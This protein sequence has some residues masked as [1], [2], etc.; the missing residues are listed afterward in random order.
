MRYSCPTRMR[1]PENTIL[2]GGVGF[3]ITE[4]MQMY[5]GKRAGDRHAHTPTHCLITKKNIQTLIANGRRR[6]TQ[7]QQ[8]TCLHEHM[9]AIE[10]NTEHRKLTLQV[11]MSS[12]GVHKCATLTH[13]YPKR[14]ETTF[15]RTGHSSEGLRAGW[16]WPTVGPHLVKQGGVQSTN[17]Q[18]LFLAT[19]GA[20]R[21]VKK[22]YDAA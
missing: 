15:F 5:M 8:R 20:R 4:Q 2:W 9:N 10:I 1:N 21:V 13:R 17:G 3:I 6:W 22:H 19:E 12:L 18:D 16:W 14:I 11:A 7:A